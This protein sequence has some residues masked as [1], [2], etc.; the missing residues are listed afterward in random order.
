MAQ[1]PLEYRV[2]YLITPTEGFTFIE[3]CSED[4]LTSELR[5][6]ILD[7]FEAKH[8]EDPEVPTHDVTFPQTPNHW[9]GWHALEEYEDHADHICW[10]TYR[11]SA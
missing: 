5:K 10:H 9:G 3:L 11:L 7:D 8:K 2:G 4:Y 1:Q 6:K